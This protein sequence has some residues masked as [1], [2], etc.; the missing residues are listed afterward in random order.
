MS[1]SVMIIAYTNGIFNYGNG[2]Y[3]VNSYVM[4]DLT[5]RVVSY[6]IE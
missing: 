3:F 1:T 4:V 5:N 2:M 6:L